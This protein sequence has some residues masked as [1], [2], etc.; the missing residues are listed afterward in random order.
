[1]TNQLSNWKE[2]ARAGEEGPSTSD[3]E[4]VCLTLGCLRGVAPLTVEVCTS[5]VTSISSTLLAKA[6]EK[7]IL[8]SVKW[9]REKTLA[10]SK[11]L[12]E[13]LPV[14]MYN[15]KICKNS[16]TTLA[17]CCKHTHTHT[18]HFHLRMPWF[19]LLNWQLQFTK[20][21]VKSFYSV[22]HQRR[23]GEFIAIQQICL[24]ANVHL[25]LN[26]P[27]FFPANS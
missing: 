19:Q 6:K 24:Y 3:V 18:R 27:K 1:M 15:F 7:T 13:N 9:W 16:I 8:Y 12:V 25:C 14:Q 23:K 11:R 17:T 22:F 4:E 21:L 2:P 20:W 5:P 26:S 10:N